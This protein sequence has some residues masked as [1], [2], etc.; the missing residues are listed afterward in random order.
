[1]VTRITSLCKYDVTYIEIVL[2]LRFIPRGS[3]DT[4]MRFANFANASIPTESE[5]FP[6]NDSGNWRRLF[7]PDPDFVRARS[8]ARLFVA[9]YKHSESKGKRATK[10]EER[11][12]L[13]LRWISFHGILSNSIQS[14]PLR[15]ALSA[16]SLSA[17]FSLSL[18]R[19]PSFSVFAF[20]SSSSTH[21]GANYWFVS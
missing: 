1:M 13:L 2:L 3:H 14:P 11:Y 7:G 12:L 18:Y 10:T 21:F 5:N 15:K 19:K 20:S 6:G 17:T 8:R 16:S 9:D 4:L